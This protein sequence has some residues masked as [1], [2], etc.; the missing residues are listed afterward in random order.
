MKPPRPLTDDQKREIVRRRLSLREPFKIIA[1][2]VG[3][4]P[5]QASRCWQLSKI[6]VAERRRRIER[7]SKQRT[8]GVARRLARKQTEARTVLA[9]EIAAARAEWATAPLYRGGPFE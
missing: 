8:R 7:H 6:G 5:A 1:R 2:S 4:S 3:C 9:G